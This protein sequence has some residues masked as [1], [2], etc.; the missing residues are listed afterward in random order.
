VPAATWQPS[1]LASGSAPAA[2]PTFA[3]AR[4]RFLGAGAWVDVVPGWVAGADE[5]FE[6]LLAGG[7]WRTRQRPMFDRMVTEPRLSTGCW[8]DPPP[9]CAEL[10][11]ALSGRY[12][13][14]LSAVSANLYRDGHDSVAWHGDTLGRHRTETVVAIVSLGQPRRFLLRPKG[15]GPSIRLTPGHGDLVALGGTCQRTWDHCVPKAAVAGSRISL[16]FREPGVF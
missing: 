11:G 3:G 6:R 5:L 9:P 10:A 4:R 7:D 12:G 16:M 13:L 1:L 14:D 15:G 2:D 8:S